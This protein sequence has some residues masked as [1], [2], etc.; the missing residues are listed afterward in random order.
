MQTKS[1]RKRQCQRKKGR[2]WLGPTPT[3]PCGTKV[4]VVY[5]KKNGK[6]RKWL[7]STPTIPCGTKVKVIYTNSPYETSPSDVYFGVTP[8]HMYFPTDPW[9]FSHYHSQSLS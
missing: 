5:T 1:I 6:G 8:N 7:G 9:C 4:K 2:E 3:I